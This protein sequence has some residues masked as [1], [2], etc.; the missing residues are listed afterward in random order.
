MKTNFSIILYIKAKP[1]A[2]GEVC[3]IPFTEN[4]V[5]YYH[6][7]S[8]FVECQTTSGEMSKCATGKFL[9]VRTP[10]NYAAYSATA[11]FPLIKNTYKGPIML[12]VY[13]L[14][15]CRNKEEC[16]V[17]DD[18]MTL[19]IE[20]LDGAF[21]LSHSYPY[22]SFEFERRWLKFE[23]TYVS[24][25][26]DI[27]VGFFSF[28]YLLYFSLFKFYFIFFL[29][30]KLEFNRKAQSPVPVVEFMIDD[31]ELVKVNSATT[32]DV[33]ATSSE[34]TTILSTET[35]NGE[36][37]EKITNEFTSTEETSTAQTTT[38]ELPTSTTAK[39]EETTTKEMSTEEKTTAT[40]SESTSTQKETSTTQSSD[41]NKPVYTCDFD[42]NPQYCGG[43]LKQTG[44]STAS[45][46]NNFIVN[47]Y[48]VTDVSSIC[49]FFFSFLSNFF[50][51]FLIL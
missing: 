16:A 30:L 24:Q 4:N 15:F 37:T 39:M 47:G 23:L 46:V 2:N 33:S 19:T 40:S 11:S 26:L 10:A 49:M 43:K 17:A 6:C 42:T 35:T 50:L 5:E 51:L 28:Y 34:K 20:K 12:R 1:A 25:G 45:N 48:K 41:E 38:T 29:K 31:I 9:Y 18:T 8:L 3:V 27:T 21:S 14:A 36:T 44:L 32:S 13:A 22:S 7:T